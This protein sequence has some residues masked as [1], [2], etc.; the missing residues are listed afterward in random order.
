MLMMVKGPYLQQPV[1]DGMTIMWQTDVSSTGEV[2]VWEL[3][4]PH[5]RTEA[6]PVSGEPRVFAAEPDDLHCVRVD[7]LLPGTDYC[8]E[9]VSRSGEDELVTPRYAFRTIPDEDEAISFLLTCECCGPT[10]PVPTPAAAPLN[11]LMRCE[12]AD[13]IQ[14]VGDC[15][16]DGRVEAYWNW[17]M[18]WPQRELL[19]S[20]PYFPCVGN[21]EVQSCHTG[22]GSS[23][24]R[25]RLFDRYFAYPHFYSYDY[26]CAHFCVLDAPAMFKAI[27]R[28]D[29]MKD[30]YVPEPIDDLAGSEQLRFL[31]EDLTASKARWKFVVLHYPPYT[32]SVYDHRELREVLCPILEKHQVD[33]MFNSHAIQYERSHPIRNGKIAPD[34]VRYI[35]C[36]GYGCVEQWLWTHADRFSAKVCGNR[37]NYVRVALTPYRLELSAIDM[38]GRLFDMLT[39]DK[40]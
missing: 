18:F 11:E 32:T 25:Y 23:A 26:G 7:G 2:R 13:F 16:A 24:D 6:M 27:G 21:H 30:R 29:A 9:V 22:D 1:R 34:G 38:Q 3:L 31:E 28:D 19:H 17:H 37:P 40:P 8:Y 36:G 33:I 5:V 15:V 12:H 20:L 4:K 14:S 39:L 35:V 10:E